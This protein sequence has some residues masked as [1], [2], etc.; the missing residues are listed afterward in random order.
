M[1]PPEAGPKAKERV[2]VDTTDREER[3]IDENMMVQQEDARMEL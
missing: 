1:L 3:A 2:A